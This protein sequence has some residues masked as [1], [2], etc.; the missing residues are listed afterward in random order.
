MVNCPEPRLNPDQPIVNGVRSKIPFHGPSKPSRQG[1][2][3]SIHTPRRTIRPLPKFP[4]NNPIQTEHQYQKNQGDPIKSPIFLVHSKLSRQCSATV[5]RWQHQVSQSAENFSNNLWSQDQPQ[6]Q[7]QTFEGWPL[8]WI[9]TEW[10]PRILEAPQSTHLSEDQ[11]V[12]P[13][14][15]QILPPNPC[16][17]RA[18]SEPNGISLKSP[19]TN[20]GWESGTWQP[21]NSCKSKAPTW[22]GLCARGGA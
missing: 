22:V 7:C 18:T 14:P 13:P 19:K 2:T 5:A 17:T 16:N 6:P 8:I 21:R 10:G 11:R 4:G 1:L 3:R 20:Q 12:E 15:W 9:W